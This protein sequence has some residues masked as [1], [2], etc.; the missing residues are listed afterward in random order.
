MTRTFIAIELGDAAR[1]Y[2]ARQIARL[3][4]DLPSVHWVDPA[5]LHLTLAFLGEL[6][7]ERLR[8]ACDAAAQAAAGAGP[9][10]LRVAGLGMFGRLNAPRVVWA[11]VGGELDHLRR[12]HAALRDAL[13]ARGFAPEERDFSPHLTLARL[14]GPLPAE[15]VARLSQLVNAARP[16]YSAGSGAAIEANVLS[17]MMSELLRPAARYTR[18]YAFPLGAEPADSAPPA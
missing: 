6:D 11:G 18:L 1:A 4:T 2:L 14:R 12:L 8:L 13:A 7:D 9:F 5:G 17:V 16:A 3:R 15:Q 10:G